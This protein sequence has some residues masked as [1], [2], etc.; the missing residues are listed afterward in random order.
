MLA[1]TR[2]RDLPA[3]T[4]VDRLGLRGDEVVADIGAGPGYFTV[5]LARALPRGRVVATDINATYLEVLR[6]RAQRAGLD[7]VTVLVTPRDE[8]GLGPRSVDLALLVQ[9]D[10][11]LPDRARAL[12]SLRES[13]RP[14]GRIVIVNYERYR[15]PL[16]AA[17]HDVGLS[18]V[19]ANAPAAGP[20]LYFV[21]LSPIPSEAADALPQ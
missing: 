3:Q 18:P 12:R 7:N 6:G 5:P 10:H 19:D 13:L 11:Y 14:R 17:A 9:V 4:L 21:A 8:P 20:D 1:S 15:E 16:L 2:E